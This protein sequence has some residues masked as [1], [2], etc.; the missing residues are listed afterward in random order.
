MST[1]SPCSNATLRRFTGKSCNSCV[2]SPGSRLAIRWARPSCSR[3]R[4]RAVRLSRAWFSP[5]RWSTST[6]SGCRAWC[7]HWSRVSTWSALARLSCPAGRARAL[8][9]NVLTTDP[10]RFARIAGILKAA[11]QLGLGD[12]TVGWL[13]AAFRLMDEFADAEY[14]R[15]TFT[16]TLVLGA[17]EDHVASTRAIERFATRLKVGRYIAIPDSQHEIL[18]ERDSIRAQFW[19]A[20]DAFIP[21]EHFS[22]AALEADAQAKRALRPSRRWWSRQGA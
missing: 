4:V 9:S 20:F 15:R 8:S 14:P 1:T 5:R 18:M 21:G 6:G 2:R 22:A 13:N 10:V 17:A 11:P 3:K 19:A 7:A 16:P 12:P